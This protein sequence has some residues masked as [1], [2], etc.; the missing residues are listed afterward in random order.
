VTEN[1]PRLRVARRIA[2]TPTEPALRPLPDGPTVAA[3]SPQRPSLTVVLLSWPAGARWYR[4]ILALWALLVQQ[5]L[6]ANSGYSWHFFADAASL[7]FGH[8]PPGDVLPGGLHLYANYPVFQFG[9]LTL[10]MSEG[11]GLFG[12]DGW[13]IVVGTM[14]LCGFVVLYLLELLVGILRPDID[15]SPRAKLGTML[16]GGASFLTSWELLAVHFGHLD[17]ILALMLLAATALTV[18]ARDATVAGLCAGLAVDAKPWALACVALL[19]GLP[20]RAK[21]R[22]G[23]VAAVAIAIAWLPF[24]LAD[25]HTL[26]ATASFTIP[27]VP[28]SALRALGV[29]TTGTPSWDRIAQIGLGCVLGVV[30]IVRRR[31]VAIIALGIGARL[32]LDPSVYTYYTAGLAMGLLLWDLTGYTKPAPLLSVLCLAGI[33]GAVYVVRN[34]HL[35]GEL[36]LWTVLL[37]IT[38]MLVA[39]R[40]EA[41][42]STPLL[43]SS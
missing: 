6:Y 32:V 31:P 13:M 40:V 5:V 14:T 17:D 12:A 9:P 22:A 29:N 15:A 27:N 20:G 38:V 1:L 3:R 41:P 33:T 42:R 30:A 25:P 8:H 37:A 26:S 36:R 10:L 4:P 7:L 16:V 23:L 35:L 2:T 28:A 24:V 39:P 43:P 34:P 11:M 19:L 18:T 21:L